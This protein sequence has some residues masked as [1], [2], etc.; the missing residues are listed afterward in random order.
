MTRSLAVVTALAASLAVPGMARAFTDHTT[1]GARPLDD[2][3][4]DAGMPQQG[5][6]GGRYF[7][8]SVRDGYTCEVCHRGGE[9][10]DGFEVEGWP[11]MEG[12]Q[13]GGGQIDLVVTL[14]D[15]DLGAASLEVVDEQGAAAGTL[16]LPATPVDEETCPASPPEQPDPYNATYLVD[17]PQERQV[18]I[19]DACAGVERM[20]VRWTPPAENVGP[21]WLNVASVGSDGSGDPEGDTVHVYARLIPPAGEGA[22]PG[23]AGTECAARPGRGAAAGA[24][25][26]LG[27]SALALLAARRRRR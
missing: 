15:V 8:G 27:L 16:E 9:P 25:A 21:L 13:P 10:Q 7:T 12:Y 18:A 24:L 23:D 14:P 11:E 6:A 17:A 22:I 26:G 2:L 5:G 4:A 1:F 19:M 3:S 20:R